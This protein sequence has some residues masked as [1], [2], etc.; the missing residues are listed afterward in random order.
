MESLLDSKGMTQ[1]QLARELF[2]SRQQVSYIFSGK[3]EMSLDMAIR[4]ESLFGLKDGTILTLQA[5]A[6][7][8]RR[9]EQ[10]RDSLIFKLKESPAFW[11]YKDV[12]PSALSDED[13]IENTILH[14]DME[15]IKQLFT[16]YGSQKVKS[17][18]KKRL[19]CQGEHLF[20]LN[21]L[22][23]MYFFGIMEPEKYLKRLEQEYFKKLQNYA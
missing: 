10:I 11:S 21:V 13:I 2:M 8:L 9:K 14:L 22:M 5:R 23:A 3:R 19:A 17:V 7:I 18:W 16:L 1:S 12:D 15:E 6:R 20:D 4:I